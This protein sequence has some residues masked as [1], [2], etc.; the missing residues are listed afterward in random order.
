MRL[1]RAGHGS[2]RP[3]NCGV[4]R[5]MWYSYTLAAVVPLQDAVRQVGARELLLAT[6][7][8]YDDRVHTASRGGALLRKLRAVCDS[9]DVGSDLYL[10]RDQAMV[11]GEELS[12]PCAR[13]S[14]LI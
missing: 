3:L 1:L 10:F 11:L 5:L 2:A 6:A 12:R 9:A 7:S 4:R 8:A 14:T 13:I